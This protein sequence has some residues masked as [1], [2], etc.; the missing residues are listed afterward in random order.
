MTAHCRLG[1]KSEMRIVATAVVTLI[2]KTESWDC[3]LFNGA[4]RVTQHN[5][6]MWPDLTVL[7]QKF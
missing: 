1:H 7:L 2:S 6:E 3:L 4:S 5:S